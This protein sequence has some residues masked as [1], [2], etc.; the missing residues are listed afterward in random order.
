MKRNILS[1]VFLLS[2]VSLHAQT[3]GSGKLSLAIGPVEVNPGVEAEAR[4]SNSTIEL[5]RVVEAIDSEMVNSF[6]QTRRFDLFARSDLSAILAEQNLAGS[7]NLDL[8][9]PNTAEA[10]RLGGVKYLVVTT[11]SDFQDYEETATFEA[12]GQSVTKRIIR[13]GAVA[14]IYDTTSGRLLESARVETTEQDIEDEPS[15]QSVRSGEMSDNLLGAISKAA[16]DNVSNRVVDVLFP[17]RIVGVTGKIVMFNRGDGFDISPG[18]VWR[19]FAEGEEMVD[20]DTGESLG[21][22][23]AE[24]GK[25][26]V[27][28]VLPRV[29]RAEIIEDYGVEKSQIVRPAE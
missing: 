9:D 7:G 17:A 4:R 24:V 13:I 2:A 15:Y 8:N 21:S 20:P 3:D 22:V 19:V 16:A 26:K 12:I 1:V 18:E 10:F 5:N 29:T 6:Q 23:E 28:E 27:I 25:V 14:K 11:I